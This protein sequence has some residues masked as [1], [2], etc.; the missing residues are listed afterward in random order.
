MTTAAETACT[1]RVSR[2]IGRWVYNSDSTYYGEA[3]W[4]LDGGPIVLDFMPGHHGCCNGGPRCCRGTYLLYGWPGRLHEPV[5]THLRA[6]MQWVEDELD[7]MLAARIGHGAVLAASFR[8]L[9]RCICGWRQSPE[10]PLLREHLREM[11]AP[12]V[13]SGV[14][15]GALG[16][17]AV[18][19]AK[20]EQ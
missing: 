2:R 17:F 20:G 16:D 11:A 6:A 3:G 9:P 5:A 14:A 10:G 1:V 8:E 12:W 7:E 13:V 4:H 19:S 18:L 15:S